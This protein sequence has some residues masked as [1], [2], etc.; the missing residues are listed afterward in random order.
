MM[1]RLAILKTRHLSALPIL[2]LLLMSIF[3]PVSAHGYIV[4]AVPEDRAVL[5]RAP[6]R[7][8]YWFSESLESDPLFSSL[9][10]R[11]QSGKIIA[12]GGVDPQNAALMTARLP[13]GLGDGAY[14]VE[15]RSAFAS[16]GHVITESRV[17][18]VGQEVGGI[19][20]QAAADQAIALEVIWRALLLSACTLLFGVFT[21]YALILVP[22]WGGSDYPAGLLPPRVMTRLYWIAGFAFVLAFVANLIA[23]MQQ[24]TA[25]FGT[26]LAQVIEQNL[27]Q[28]VRI[29][30][31]FGDVWNARTLFLVIATL[32]FAASLYYRRSQPEMVRPFWMA[33]V[34]LMPL[35]MGTFSAASHAAGSL[36]LP[37]VG[38]FFD[39]LHTIAVGLWIGG[40][41]ALVL[42]LPPALR[43]YSG[44][45]RL[46]ALV[47]VL[48]RFSRL[49]LGS[50][51]V[52]IATG[53]YNSLT[54]I[55]TPDDAATSFGAALMLKLLLVVL[56][57]LV[58]ALH[59]IALHPQ[60][61]RRLSAIG[62]RIGDFITTLRLEMLL[63][64]AVLAAAGLLTATPVPVP[65]FAQ[66][67]AEAPRAEQTVGDY[68]VALTITPGG[69]GIN[70][71]D[72][73]ITRDGLL[74]DGLT[75]RL[76]AVSPSRDFRTPP[77]TLEPVDSGLY[78]SAGADIDRAGEWWT[79]VDFRDENGENLRA[80]FEWTI[81]QDAAVIESRNPGVLHI[82]A[83]F[84]VFGA[85]V[86]AIMPLLRRIYPNFDF[87]AVNVTVAVGVVA[88][89]VVLLAV[90]GQMVE[91]SRLRYEQTINPPPR[92]IN[93]TIPDAASL[94]RGQVIYERCGWMPDELR[95]LVARL[96]RTRDEELFTFTRDGWS[97][98]PA[99]P[100]DDTQR[101]DLVNF[102]R[103]L[104]S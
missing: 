87:N 39:W 36:M 42:V 82:A 21:L 3:Q 31:R 63:A 77:Q 92:I 96:P 26:G 70:T 57:L 66:I 69:P 7:V 54:W 30:S 33:N 34:W 22:A 85:L 101:W 88:A 1:K 55:S 58:A 49:A 2:F 81:S 74:V 94:E 17:F 99:C 95:V 38:V 86:F 67:Q 51:V 44:E 24:S 5:E 71:Y 20:G 79:L 19:T 6:V 91:E 16:D 62:S 78:V 72:V 48:N 64:L 83:L 76:Q 50:A 80:A 27:W 12:T 103:T 73:V 100:A 28:V 13:S 29:G 32:L 40:L 45:Q 15:I 37:W 59:Y 10:I 65:D 52:V 18:F 104:E 43:P 84:T 23:L 97:G 75:A 93:P 61:F 8:Q 46:L 98:L 68:T 11:N 89:T 56:L 47:A 102:I 9:N 60:R 90:G 53:I 14:I 41:M 35:I 4:R 25:F